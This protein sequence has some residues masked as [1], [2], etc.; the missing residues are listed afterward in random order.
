M[1]NQNQ[2]RTYAIGLTLLSALGRLV[3]HVPNVTPLGS[4]CLFAG[5]RI[6]GYLAYLLPLAVMIATDPFVGGY[7]YGSPLIYAS[8]MLSVWIGRQMVKKDVT[9]TRVG[10]AALLCSTQFFIISNFGVWLAASATAHPYYAPNMAGLIECYVSAIP[11]WGYTVAGDLFYSA[12]IFGL[13]ALLTR[14][15]SQTAERAAA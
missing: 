10:G 11:Y 5:S 7:T 6:G 14:R 13:Y 9:V 1:G 12:A 4:S 8:F 15:F 2:S 3:P